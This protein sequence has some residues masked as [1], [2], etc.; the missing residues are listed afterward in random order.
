MHKYERKNKMNNDIKFTENDV[1]KKAILMLK[2]NLLDI[3]SYINNP[4]SSTLKLQKVKVEILKANDRLNDIY[5]VLNANDETK[6]IEVKKLCNMLHEE[7]QAIMEEKKYTEYCKQEIKVLNDYDNNNKTTANY[8][9]DEKYIKDFM[10]SYP[11]YTR[12]DAEEA[13]INEMKH[14]EEYKKE[15]QKYEQERCERFLKKHN[16]FRSVFD[17]CYE[18]KNLDKDMEI[19]KNYLEKNNMLSTSL[20][21]GSHDLVVI[22][23]KLAVAKNKSKIGMLVI[24]KEENK[25]KT[26]KDYSRYEIISVKPAY[27]K[28]NLSKRK[29]PTEIFTYLISNNILTAKDFKKYSINQFG[30]TFEAKMGD[31]ILDNELPEALDRQKRYNKVDF[32]Q[33][34]KSDFKGTLYISN[35]WDKNSIDRLINN[36]E[37]NY[38]EYISIITPEVANIVAYAYDEEISSI[39]KNGLKIK[40]IER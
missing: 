38:G 34:P 10:E 30:R 40:H 28:S 25:Y 37:L 11:G 4:M 27:V 7:V 16:N 9:V 18:D 13:F 14:W 8:K 23:A 5:N 3:K 17:E 29:L 20:P 31:I 33:Y 21:G 39:D 24:P 36:I 32:S 26:E 19:L 6:L 15:Y 2:E 35:Q 1:I 12:H 22:R